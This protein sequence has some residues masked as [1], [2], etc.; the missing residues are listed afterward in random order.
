M[1]TNLAEYYK[2]RAKEYEK[3]YEKLERQDEI[4]QATKILQNIFSGK[5]VLE[6]AC[7]TGFWTE[8]IAQTAAS[9]F[10]TDINQAVIEIAKQKNHGSANVTFQIDDFFYTAYPQK[11]ENLFGGFIWSH[12]KLEELDIFLN[13]IRALVKPGGTIVLM[14][15]NYMED[16]SRPI[17]HT[18]EKGNTYQLRLLDDSSEH[19]VLKNFQKEDFIKEKLKEKATAVSF[20]N[21][22]YFWIL[23]F[24][25]SSAQ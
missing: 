1:N 5:D 20:T 24:S 8:R 12:I 23:C 21:L 14:D 3:I 4:F 9:I 13:T 18:D 15:N 16:S 25:N 2:Q 6:I 11:Y 7:G 17:T 10:A 22:K 19:L